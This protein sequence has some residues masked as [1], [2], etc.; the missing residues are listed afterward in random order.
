MKMPGSKDVLTV[1]GDTKKALGAL[2]FALKTA[3]VARPANEA[4][5]GA[6]EAAPAKNKQLFTQDRAETKQVSVE[7]DG[8]SGATFTI[9]ANL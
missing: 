3:A 2:K 9:G 8:P 4:T 1:V 6:K 7:E 5:P